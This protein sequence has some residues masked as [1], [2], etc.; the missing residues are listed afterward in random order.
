MHTLQTEVVLND[1]NESV[2]SFFSNIENLER[3]TPDWLNFTILRQTPIDIKKGSLFYFQIRIFKVP[4]KWK[5]EITCWEPPYRFIDE[6]LKGPYKKWIHEHRFI[7]EGNQTRMI[8]IVNYQVPGWFFSSLI[9]KLFVRN[10]VKK[11]FRYRKETIKQ[12]FN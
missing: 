11:I 9:H 3:I 2:F 6:Q 5:T 7:D 8:D 10:A 12:I 4:L 1:S